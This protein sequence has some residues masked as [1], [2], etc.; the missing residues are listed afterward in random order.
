MVG[1]YPFDDR[2]VGIL[3]PIDLLFFRLFA[4]ASRETPSDEDVGS[5]FPVN[6]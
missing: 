5:S 4:W 6:S 1:R 2:L 3:T